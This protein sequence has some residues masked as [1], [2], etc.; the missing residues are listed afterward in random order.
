MNFDSRRDRAALVGLAGFFITG[1]IVAVGTAWAFQRGANDF[2]VFYEA[3][4]LVLDGRGS[5]VYTSTPDRYL[6]APGFAWILAPLG[7][8]PRNIA[9]AIWCFAKAGAIG[10]VL[11]TFRRAFN[12]QGLTWGTM[13]C[14]WATLIVAR[15]L[16]IDFQY[17]QVNTF[18]LAACVW[19]VVPRFNLSR[20]S[21]WDGIRWAVLAIAALA[22]IYPLPLLVVPWVVTHGISEARLRRE[23]WGVAIGLGLIFSVPMISL[24]WGGTLNL[25]LGWRDALVA[26]GMPMESHNQ[27]FTALLHHY[28][29]GEATHVISRGWEQVKFGFGWISPGTLS[30]LTLAWTFGTLGIVLGWLVAGPAP[31]PVRWSGIAVGLPIISSYLIWKPYMVMA[32]PAAI[33]ALRDTIVDHL[34]DESIARFCVLVVIFAGLNLSGFD[35][36]GNELSGRFEAASGLLLM[37]LML[38]GLVRTRRE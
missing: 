3:W 35:F 14:A 27:S 2:N 26:R 20:A 28:F 36:V 1:L 18:I 24:G 9:L 17:G 7:V 22:K 23:R 30:L 29:A 33:L 34:R 21:S 13:A 15:P 6:Y 11:Q 16:L 37:H 12:N 4:R 10:L 5:G 32:L 38:L 31:S 8:F 19:A 25:L